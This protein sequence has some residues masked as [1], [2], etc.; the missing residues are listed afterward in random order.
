M[1]IKFLSSG[2]TVPSEPGGGGG[3]SSPIFWPTSK[4]YLNQEGG[5]DY[6]HHITTLPLQF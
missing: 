1:G 6:T 3:E 5:A 4:T 2:L